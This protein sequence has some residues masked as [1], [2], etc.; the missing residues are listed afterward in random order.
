MSQGM[1]VQQ[2]AAAPSMD[3]VN[4]KSQHQN[5]PTD[6]AASR[7]A[8]KR[9]NAEQADAKASQVAKKVLKIE[10]VVDKAMKDVGR[11]DIYA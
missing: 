1:T 8:E 4:V 7:R 5:T 11:I 2:S 6:E 3:R 9:A 10:T